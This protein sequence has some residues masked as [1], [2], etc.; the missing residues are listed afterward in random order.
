LTGILIPNS[1]TDIN[2]NAFE[3][4][5]ITQG[6]AQIDNT[7][8]NVTIGDYAFRYNGVARETTITPTYLR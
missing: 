4:N 6:N 3:F 5:L 8:G 2:H 1:V 7:Q